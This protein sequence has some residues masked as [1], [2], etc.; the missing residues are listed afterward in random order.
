MVKFPA[1][2]KIARVTPICKD[3]DK[4]AKENYRPISVLPVIS[5]L[6]EKIIYNQMY[7]YLN[8]HGFLLSNQSGL[9]TLHSTLTALLKNTDD[10]YS[11]MDFGKY[12]GTVFVELKRHLTLSIIIFFC[13]NL[14]IM[15][16]KSF[17]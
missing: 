7:K 5:R 6:F 1:S 15:G 3:G 4:S 17:T 16:F 10:W 8:S 9:K 11:G 12:V 13:R 14:T 2:W